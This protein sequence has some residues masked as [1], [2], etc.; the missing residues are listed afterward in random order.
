MKGATTTSPATPEGQE[1]RSCGGWTPT[2]SSRSCSTTTRWSTRLVRRGRCS[3]G[4]PGR[5]AY[6]AYSVDVTGDEVYELRFRDLTTGD[7]LPDQVAHTYY[8][9]AWSADS[10]TFFYVVHDEVYRP[11]QVW[12]H[13]VGTDASV[14]RPRLR[15]PRHRSTTSSSGPTARGDLIVISRLQPQHVRG[16]ARRRAPTRRAGVGGQRLD[17]AASS[18]ASRTCPV[19]RRRGQLLVVT[20]DGAQEFR[21]MRAP[22]RHRPT[23]AV[24]RGVPGVADIRLHDVDVFARHVVLS[25]VSRRTAAAAGAAALRSCA[26][27]RPVVARRRARRRRRDPRWAAH[28]V[29]QRGA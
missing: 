12:R 16:V 22:V 5:H 21:L 4:Q 15:G 29:A 18:T 2:G 9:G 6:L 10:S 8:G 13:R 14:G 1:H 28:A 17:D 25:T 27:G 11:Y 26:A 24:A 23:R 19:Q 7:D 20:N 3:F